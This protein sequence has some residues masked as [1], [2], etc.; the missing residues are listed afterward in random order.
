MSDVMQTQTMERTAIEPVDLARYIVDL[1]ADKKGEQIVLMDIREHTVIADYFVICSGSS[2]RQLKTIIDTIR[3]EVKK[4]HQ[5][6]AHHVE[7]EAESGWV[8]IDYGDVIV[9]AFAPATRSYY[10][11]EGLWKEAPIL[12]KMQ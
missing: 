8:L 1:I 7:G 10:D 6:Q 2:E 9:H 12:L 3:E 4:N 5:I 11:L